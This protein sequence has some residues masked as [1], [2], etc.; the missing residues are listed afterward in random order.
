MKKYIFSII[1]PFLL[2]IISLSVFVRISSAQETSEDKAKKFGVAFPVAEL[3]NCASVSECRTYCEDQ[4]HR[5]ACVSFA[6]KKDSI[7][8]KKLIQNGKL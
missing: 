1:V 6:K 2:L 3:G 5:D 8:K 4:T 7:R